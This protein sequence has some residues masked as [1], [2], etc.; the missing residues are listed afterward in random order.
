MFPMS[1][2]GRS[3]A[4]MRTFSYESYKNF[5]SDIGKNLIELVV[6]AENLGEDGL[7][8][9]SRVEEGAL[10][11]GLM[12]KISTLLKN[13]ISDDLTYEK[14]GFERFHEKNRHR[15]DRQRYRGRQR[16]R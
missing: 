2:K 7:T 9:E 6:G 4:E 12:K 3:S 15:R 11:V 16:R 14:Y 5:E 1:E 10:T 8:R 13:S